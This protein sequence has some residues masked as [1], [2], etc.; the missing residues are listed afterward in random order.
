[1]SY[2]QDTSVSVER[3]QAQIQQ[4]IISRG[5]GQFAAMFDLEHSRAI[6]LWTMNGRQIKLFVPLPDQNEDRFKFP[7]RGGKHQYHRENPEGRRRTL[8]EQSCRSRWRAILLI[9][10]AK[11]EAIDSGC[12]TFER[13]FLADTVMANGK[14]LSQWAEPQVE[15]MLVS[16]KMPK[17][18]ALL[19]DGS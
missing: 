18:I 19:G 16:G 10:K 7:T 15:A 12:T 4:L 9:V 14:T 11:F 13:E 6:V 1:M 2:A 5:A 17:S 3:S 8:W